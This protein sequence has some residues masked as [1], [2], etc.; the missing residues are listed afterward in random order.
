MDYAINWSQTFEPDAGPSLG[1]LPQG[2]PFCNAALNLKMQN[3]EVSLKLIGHRQ[4][5]CRCNCATK[6]GKGQGFLTGL[7]L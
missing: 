1:Q 6:R 3:L 5:P 4:S 7:D 2:A